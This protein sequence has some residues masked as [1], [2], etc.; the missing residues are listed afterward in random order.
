MA[1]RLYETVGKG[2]TVAVVGDGS[3]RNSRALTAAGLTVVAVEDEK[4][5][6]QLPFAARE[7]DGALSTHA[8]LHG[9]AAKIRSGIAEL[10]RVL[11]PEAP[12]FLTFGSIQDVRYGFGDQL[13]AHTFAPGEGAEI[14]VPHAYFDRDALLDV[15]RPLEIVCAEEVAVDA[16]VGKWAH[17]SDEPPG[18]VHWFVE[19]RKGR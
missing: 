5:Y 19:V 9:T 17:L 18:K 1:R 3:G 15:L 13:D 10:A 7:L 16:I 14:G 2:R 4:P 12:A 8:Y 11:R 6:T